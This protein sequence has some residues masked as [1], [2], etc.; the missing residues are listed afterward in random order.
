MIIP[1][2][3]SFVVATNNWKFHWKFTMDK[4]DFHGKF[5]MANQCFIPANTCEIPHQ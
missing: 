5:P 1:S 4:F 3:H 2:Y